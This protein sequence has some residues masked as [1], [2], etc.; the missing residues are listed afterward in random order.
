MAYIDKTEVNKDQYLQIR[1]FW[2]DT[3][4]QQ[5]KDLGRVQWLYPFDEFNNDI[6]FDNINESITNELLETKKDVESFTEPNS[7]RTLWN[8]GTAFDI[9]LVKNCPFDFIQNRLK[10]QYGDDW[11]VFKYKDELKFDYKE[12]NCFFISIEYQE[13]TIYFFREKGEDIEPDHVLIHEKIIVYG[14]TYIFELIDA[15]IKKVG[16]RRGISTSKPG[17][18]I[19]VNYY[20][21]TLLFEN[22]K[23]KI[24]DDFID[25]IRI[26][27]GEIKLPEI[28]HSY[29]ISDAEQYKD[30]EIFMSRQNDCF[31]ITMYENYDRKHF[32]R[33]IHLLPDYINKFIK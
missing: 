7:I 4:E 27:E 13:S 23:I 18:R 30:E 20:G 33:Y 31:D 19:V 24:G 29:L 22:G 5:I 25:E 26:G 9:W 17:M 15:A 14:T 12:G 21:I 11:F 1:Q 6:D 28:K 3:R 8:T 2:I 10:E 32:K 16:N